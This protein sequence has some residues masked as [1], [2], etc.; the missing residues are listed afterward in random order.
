MILDLLRKVYNFFVDTIQTLVLVF[1]IFLIVYIFLFRPFQVN[2]DSMYP[3]FFNK[4]YIL[5][6]IVIL[7]FKKPKLGDVIIFR[8]P[9]APDKDYIKRVIGVPDDV[10]SIKEG[11]VYLNGKLLNEDAY[12]SSSIRTY[13]GRFLQDGKSVTVPKNSYFVMGDNRFESSDSREWGF[14]SFKSVI[15]E[16]FFIYWPLNKIGTVKNP[17][18]N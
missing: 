15:G 11:Y 18:S 7:H 4:E 8:A 12:V 5:T 1:A 16:S 13:G 17:Y 2:G 9:P 10:L 3:N 14:V 6:N